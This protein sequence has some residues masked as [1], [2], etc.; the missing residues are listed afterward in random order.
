MDSFDRDK[1]NCVIIDD[2]RAKTTADKNR[3]D[4][5]FGFCSTH[6]NTTIL[7]A[8]QD[9]FSL[10]SPVIRRMSNVFI[11]WKSFDE[12]QLKMIANRVGMAYDEVLQI[13]TDL[14]FGPKD[15]LCI[16]KTDDTPAPLRKNLFQIIAEEEIVE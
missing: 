10:F 4:R 15:N 7:Y 16:D 3:L 11:L 9:V 5:F 14:D 6:H 2:W 1:K 12:N 8:T 13:M